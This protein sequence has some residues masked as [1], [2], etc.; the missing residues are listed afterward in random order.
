[1]NLPAPMDV[2][3][4][5]QLERSRRRWRFW[6]IVLGVILGAIV[7]FG[8]DSDEVIGSYVANVRIDGFIGN[9]DDRLEALQALESDG[10]AKAVLVQIDSPG[11]TMVGGL[12]LFDAL[13]R[14]AEHKP[15]VTVMGT[16]A[17]S[18]GYMVALAGD[19]MVA[20]PATLTGSIGVFM[21]LFDVR[22]LAH[23]I[24]IKSEEVASG[25]MKT[26]TSPL[27]ERDAKDRAYLQ[28]LVERLQAIFMERVQRRRQLPEDVQRYVADGRALIGTQA[29]EL[30]LADSLGGV[31][32]ARVWLEKNHKVDINTPAVEVE[33]DAQGGLF[34]SLFGQ[35][36]TWPLPNMENL[37][38]G[39]LA[40]QR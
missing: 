12:E 29:V 20:S 26:V 16:T 22:E 37:A 24:G 35:A 13:R 3:A 8:W 19:H 10:D 36:F 25:D 17:A 2:I 32:E 31:Y 27:S 11:G 34:E 9:N 33:W 40:V 18:A 5:M 39:V 30:G 15:V 21:P 14:L 28:D 6:A 23:K 7:Y 4:A 1:M 38:F